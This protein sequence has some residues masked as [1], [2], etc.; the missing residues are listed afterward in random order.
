MA[1]DEF[2]KLPIIGRERHFENE[3]NKS[4]EK[5]QGSAHASKGKEDEIREYRMQNDSQRNNSFD[6]KFFRHIFSEMDVLIRLVTHSG[7]SI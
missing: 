7:I 6:L 4:S 1:E 5:Q 3:E 2:A